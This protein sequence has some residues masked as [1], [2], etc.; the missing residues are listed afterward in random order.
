LE[1]ENARVKWFLSINST[2]LPAEIREKGKTTYRSITIDSEPL[3]F[4]DG[5]TDLHTI[6][7]TEI[8]A[9]RGFTLQDAKPAVCLA[10]EIRDMDT[11][12][13]VGEYHPFAK[14][15]QVKHPFLL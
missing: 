5:F 4:S 7:Y 9:G 14:L 2:T 3:E 1:F 11:I 12:G 6:S 15:P 8:L 10:H 13:L